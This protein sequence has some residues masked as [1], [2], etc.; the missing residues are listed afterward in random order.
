MDIFVFCFAFAHTV[1]FSR[2]MDQLEAA[3]DGDLHQL[4]VALTVNNVNDVSRV[5]GWI[6]LHFAARNGHDEWSNSVS[7]WAPM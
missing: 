2:V 5:D 3:R 1:S 7:R 4:R 6:A